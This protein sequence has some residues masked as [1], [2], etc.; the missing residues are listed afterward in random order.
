MKNK[1]PFVG[2]YVW[3]TSFP[4]ASWPSKSKFCGSGSPSSWG[5]LHLLRGGAGKEG[6][7]TPGNAEE[8]KTIPPAAYMTLS[9]HS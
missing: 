4:F 5:W 2:E 7:A 6:E 3:V 9:L 8:E 1:P